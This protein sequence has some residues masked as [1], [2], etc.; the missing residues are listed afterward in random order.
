[1]KTALVTGGA[2]FIGSHL[3]DRLLSEN[4][5]TI[6]LDAL[7]YAG[8]IDNL[9]LAKKNELFTFV[10]GDI[11]D[12][13]LV[14]NLL[15]E[16]GV[17][18]IFHLAAESHV[19]NSISHPGAFV[20]TNV[21]GTYTMLHAARQ[22]WENTSKPATFRFVHV[23]TD[24]VFGQLKENDPP[25]TEN[26]PYAPR[27]PYSATKAASDHLAYAW[28]ATYGLPVIITN[29]SNNFGPRQHQ[30]KLIPTIIRNALAGNSIPIYGNG[31]N[32]RDWLYVSDHVKG[33]ILAAKKGK[34][35]Q[36]YCLGGDWEL[37]NLDMAYKICAILDSL[38]PRADGK[39]YSNQIS[40]V[41]DRKGHDWRYAIDS[42][43][44]RS[45]LD[46]TPSA[47][48]DHNLKQTVAYFAD[49]R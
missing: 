36:T 25:F 7:T 19:D 49:K 31:K 39:S 9:A 35:G 12:E 2:G 30:E 22:F 17:D 18:S 13:N 6:V 26:T 33:L 3:V 16:H 10:K 27:S 21:A 28:H 24:E 46:F 15:Q 47:D 44:A 4:V 1:M 45:E 23:S 38:N 11:C 14:L 29:C 43:R 42:T 40:F 8:N 48:F 20:H 34:P 5:Q 41:E 37:Q 32:I